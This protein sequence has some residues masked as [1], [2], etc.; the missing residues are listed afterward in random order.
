MADVLEWLSEPLGGLAALGATRR[1]GGWDMS[2]SD[3]R[4]FLRDVKPYE[5]PESLES[6]HGPVHGVVVL[7]HSVLWSPGGGEVDL[8]EAGGINLAYRAVIA[9]GKVADQV[10][11][12]NRGRLIEVWGELLLPRRARL[13]WEHRFPELKTSAAA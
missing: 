4:V 10:E 1:S 5:V 11:V 8:D 7:R 6:L 2:G 3:P 13:M 9:E 12:L